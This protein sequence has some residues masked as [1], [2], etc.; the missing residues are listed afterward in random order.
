MLRILPGAGGDK[1]WWMKRVDTQRA[2]SVN[3][4]CVP[5]NVIVDE[6]SEVP[7]L[8]LKLA[9]RPLFCQW[10]CLI[11]LLTIRITS[12]ASRITISCRQGSTWKC[13][14]Q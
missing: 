3:I 8:T 9:T 11:L 12:S 1:A 4:L 10:H 14:G 2:V 7:C 5:Q 6:E 13:E